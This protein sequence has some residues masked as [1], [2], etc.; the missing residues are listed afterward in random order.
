MEDLNYSS[1][2]YSWSSTN[3]SEEVLDLS[4]ENIIDGSWVISLDDFVTDR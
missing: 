2:I 1:I 4:S 3:V